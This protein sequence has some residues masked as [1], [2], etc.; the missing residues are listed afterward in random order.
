MKLCTKCGEEKEYFNK[1]M[2][3]CRD[4]TKAY[5][6]AKR[7]EARGG[8]PVREVWRDFTGELVRCRTC[9]VEKPLTIENFRPGG[10]SNGACIRKDCRECCNAERRAYRQKNVKQW[11]KSSAYQASRDDHKKGLLSTLTA[12]EMM[13]HFVGKPCMY[14]GATG[15]MGA[16]RVDNT[17]AHSVENC[18]P[19]CSLC[20]L[21]RNNRFTVEEMVKHIGPAI[22]KIREER[23]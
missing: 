3:W 21:T 5:A 9:G 23:E 2:S 15:W 14:C 8:G 10:A 4:C 22:R 18:V 13:D 7:A 11:C 17:K 12:E 6:A 16:D 1:G 20:N 19:A